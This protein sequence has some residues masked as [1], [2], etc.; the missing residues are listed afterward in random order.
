MHWDGYVRLRNLDDFL[1]SARAW[2][3]ASAHL[4]PEAGTGGPFVVDWGDKVRLVLLDTAWWLL[5][6]DLAERAGV[7]ERIDEAFATA[8]DREMMLMAHH[9]FRS[10]GPHGGGFNVWEALGLRYILHRS[11]AILQDITSEPYRALEGSLRAIFAQHGPP[12]AFIGGHEH[13][14]QVLRSVQASDPEYNLVSGSASKLSRIGPAEGM[15]FGLSSPGYIR[16]VI[17]KSG[18][19]TMFVEAAPPEHLECGA[20]DVQPNPCT[21]EGVASFETVFSRRLR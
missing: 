6:A 7:V 16:L 4:V 15:L 3:G 20:S 8:G 12:L 14:L 10:G 19:I 13:S 17:E 21:M 9:P 11:G 5:E 18:G 1:V 2:S